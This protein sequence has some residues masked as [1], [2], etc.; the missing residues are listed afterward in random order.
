MERQTGG[1]ASSARVGEDAAVAV[2]AEDE[3]ATRVARGI[4]A[5]KDGDAIAVMYW[6]ARE[7]QGGARRTAGYAF[8]GGAVSLGKD[9]KGEGK[10]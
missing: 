4:D 7:L 6:T 2:D 10:E 9:K 1:G 8:G 3:R 5:G